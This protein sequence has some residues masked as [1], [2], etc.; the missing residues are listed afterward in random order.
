MT[1]SPLSVRVHNK[2]AINGRNSNTSHDVWLAVAQFSPTTLK[3]RFD[4]VKNRNV[5]A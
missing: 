3:M 5:F 4:A 2:Q 1:P